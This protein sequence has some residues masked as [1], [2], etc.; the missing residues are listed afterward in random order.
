[1]KWNGEPQESE[2]MTFEW[3]NLNRVPVEEMWEGDKIWFPTVI[4][5]KKSLIHLF[6]NDKEKQPLKVEVNFVKNIAES[7]LLLL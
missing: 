6:F 7:S 1:M 5:N 2:G 3:H 4:K